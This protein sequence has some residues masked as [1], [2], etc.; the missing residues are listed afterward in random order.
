MEIHESIY[1]LLMLLTYVMRRAGTFTL[2]EKMKMI[3]FIG[4]IAKNSNISNGGSG[5]TR[6]CDHST[7][8]YITQGK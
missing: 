4:Y 1:L 3:D 2:E 6:E 5:Q 7:T 8:S